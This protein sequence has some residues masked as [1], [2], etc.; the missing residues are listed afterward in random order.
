MLSCLIWKDGV[1]FSMQDRQ[2]DATN[3]R[4][5]KHIYTDS[6]HKAWSQW[7]EICGQANSYLNNSEF[8][9]CVYYMFCIW[10]TLL[11]YHPCITSRYTCS[12]VF[13][14]LFFTSLQARRI[15][16]TVLVQ[17]IFKD[18]KAMKMFKCMNCLHWKFKTEVVQ[19]P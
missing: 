17:C 5:I 11:N 1:S 3:I 6:L 12:S 16:L 10:I 14:K 2:K 7:V 9:F 8:W 18:T 13:T 4:M 19:L 15:L